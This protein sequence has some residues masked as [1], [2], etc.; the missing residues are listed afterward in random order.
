[1][2]E[3]ILL[4]EHGRIQ[5]LPNFFGYSYYLRNGKSYGF[6]IWPLHSDGPSE[7]TPIKILEKMARG[8]DLRDMRYENIAGISYSCVRSERTVTQQVQVLQITCTA[9][10]RSNSHK[11]EGYYHVLIGSHIRAF[12]WYQNQ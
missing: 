12:D 7:E 11:D 6:Q 1:M 9:M 5:G 2:L 8:P 10:L 4:R 3:T